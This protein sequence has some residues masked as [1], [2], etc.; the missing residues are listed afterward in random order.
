MS[1]FESVPLGDRN[2]DRRRTVDGNGLPTMH[3]VDADLVADLDADLK[4]VES[5]LRRLP[6]AGPSHRLAERMQLL[7]EPQGG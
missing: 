5:S 3:D 6:L 1:L 2:T 4:S 7:F